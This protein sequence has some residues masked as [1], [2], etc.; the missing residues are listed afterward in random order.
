MA[1]ELISDVRP[2]QGTPAAFPAAYATSP[3]RMRS[4]AAVLIRPFHIRVAPT[5]SR[6]FEAPRKRTR[7]SNACAMAIQAV[8][9]RHE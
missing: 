5:R 4:V 3:A 7:V 6:L 8:E 2:S 1:S 9:V